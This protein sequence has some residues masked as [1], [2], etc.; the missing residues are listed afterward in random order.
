MF[1]LYNFI[2]WNGNPRTMHAKTI[3]RKV[4]EASKNSNYNWIASATEL[5]YLC[6]KKDFPLEY[7][8]DIKVAVLNCFATL[9][10]SE[11]DQSRSE[12]TDIYAVYYAYNSLYDVKYEKAIEARMN[13][14]QSYLKSITV[15]SLLFL[16]YD[17]KNYT[18]IFYEWQDIKIKEL[19]SLK[20]LNFDTI[21]PLLINDFKALLK[22]KVKEGS[23]KSMELV[24]YVDEVK[25]N[26]LVL[27]KK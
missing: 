5:I 16:T 11:N 3:H 19:I 10:N 14:L 6:D 13:F 22:S 1:G 18:N 25:E 26:K 12:E 9:I 20:E 23:L 4:M 15:N 17:I 8:I 2:D 7:A 27:K 24:G 21:K